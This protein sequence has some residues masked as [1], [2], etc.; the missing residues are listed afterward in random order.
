MQ[1]SSKFPSAKNQGYLTSRT[2]K[3]NNEVPN[4]D[5]WRLIV[6]KCVPAHTTPRARLGG[7]KQPTKIDFRR[8][9]NCREKRT[10][11]KNRGGQFT[12]SNNSLCPQR[13]EG[14]QSSRS[15]KTKW[16]KFYRGKE[17][18]FMKTDQRASDGG[19]QIN[20]VVFNGKRW[21]G[22]HRFTSGVSLEDKL[23]T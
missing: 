6:V 9:I 2:M 16:I 18:F 3:I 8:H 12:H 5:L 15:A 20:K 4:D 23:Q 7:K 21:T 19:K 1:Q 10:A 11:G 14:C 17:Q 22:G 13:Q